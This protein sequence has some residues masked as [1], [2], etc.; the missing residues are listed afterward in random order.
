M[1]EASGIRSGRKTFQ[2]GGPTFFIPLFS[3]KQADGGKSYGFFPSISFSDGSESNQYPKEAA[4][5]FV[6]ES[7]YRT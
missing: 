6:L 2:T 7:I 4:T 5:F 1:P 3:K